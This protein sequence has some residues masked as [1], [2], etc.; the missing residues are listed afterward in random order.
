MVVYTGL[1]KIN[2][3][4]KKIY[5]CISSITQVQEIKVEHNANIKFY[6][7]IPITNSLCFKL[8]LPK[9]LG[10]NLELA[11][12]FIG[13]KMNDKARGVIDLKF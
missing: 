11:F 12:W 4:K 7:P 2:E 5:K 8:I 1:I 3:R 9:H 6:L 13:M 10:K